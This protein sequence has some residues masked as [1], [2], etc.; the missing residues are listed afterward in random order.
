MSTGEIFKSGLVFHSISQDAEEMKE[1]SAFWSYEHKQYGRGKFEGK[2]T[3]FHTR[4]FQVSYSSRSNGIF[5]RGGIPPATTIITFNFT[6]PR[7]IFYRGHI[8]QDSQV[9]ALYHSEELEY[10]TLFPSATLTVAV[11]TELL[12]D[13]FLFINGVPFSSLRSQERLKIKSLKLY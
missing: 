6:D 5:V 7:K 12:N 11:N 13:R 2:I 1:Q 3:A 4:Q 9:M 8:L 10:H